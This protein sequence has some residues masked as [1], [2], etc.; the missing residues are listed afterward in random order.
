MLPSLFSRSEV[1]GVFLSDRVSLSGSSCE[2][3]PTRV[4]HFFS[5]RIGP[6][7]PLTFLARDSDSAANL[8]HSLSLTPMRRSFIYFDEDDATSLLMFLRRIPPV[9]SATLLVI[10]DRLFI[11]KVTRF[12]SLRDSLRA[13][14]TSSCCDGLGA[15]NWN[16]GNAISGARNRDSAS[17]LV[18]LPQT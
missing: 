15:V 11:G 12:L 18:W 3:G 8:S 9:S 16:R 7:F 6:S 5:S 17:S 14:P 10:A 13:A 2:I 4:C 1:A